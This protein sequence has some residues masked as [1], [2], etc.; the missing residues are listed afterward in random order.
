MPEKPESTSGPEGSGKR[1]SAASISIWTILALLTFGGL[2]LYNHWERIVPPSDKTVMART[3]AA[4]FKEC[5]FACTNRLALTDKAARS[6]QICEKYC[7]CFST[8]LFKRVTISEVRTREPKA[9]IEAKE[10]ASRK[11]CAA[12]LTE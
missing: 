6:I 8:D 5:T 11:A 10:K 9:A 12:K 4:T 7:R 3:E 1:K 2:L